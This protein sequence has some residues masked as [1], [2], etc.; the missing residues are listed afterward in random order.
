MNSFSDSSS[1]QFYRN[2]IPLNHIINTKLI[3][4]ALG[5]LLCV[6]GGLFLI[7]MGV[8]LYYHEPEYLDFI[9]SATI[10]FTLGSILMFYGHGASTW[11]TRR[12]GYC[13][14]TLTWILFTLLGMMPFLFSGS[15]PSVSNAFFESMSGFTT[16]GFTVVSNIDDLPRGIQFWRI[17]TQWV[18]ALGIVCFTIAMLPIFGGGNLQLFS[19]E[20]TGVRHDKLHPKI[21][22]NTKLIWTVY[23]LLTGICFGLLY[24][25]GMGGFDSIC[26]SLSIM[27]TGGYSTKQASLAYWDSPFIEYVA[28]IFM[29]I[30]SCNVILLAACMKGRFL[31]LFKD[32][33][34]RW[35]LGSVGLLTA[36]I[37][38][39]LFIS[40]DYSIEKAFRSAFFQVSTIHSSCGLITDDYT[41]W[42]QFTWMLLLF[43]M[44]AGGCTG[45][46]SGAIKNLRIM[47]IFRSIRN[48][49][50]RMIHPNAI[51]PVRVN[52][53]VLPQPMLTTVTVFTIF[54]FICGIIG[55]TLF[56]MMGID[57]F[58][59]LTTA[60]SAMGNIG[61]SFGYYGP[62]FTLDS[63]PELGKWVMSALMLI[64]RLE[65]FNVLILFSA[66]FWDEW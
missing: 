53:H 58:E 15:I 9:Y 52:C 48:E 28:A 32:D 2:R 29:V 64:G 39:T 66:V 10:N 8:S 55:C 3:A 43:A 51:L 57:F 33:E 44:L 35:F 25:G 62:S 40:T 21:S 50:K 22:V 56:M 4:Y 31:K 18:G 38:I 17:L 23:I 63:M 37:T 45:S 59:A 47:I 19:A 42:P 26:H 16:T 11:M 34:T 1:R 14:V 36:I 6:E 12:D 30:S 20:A 60:I 61:V 24:V 5:I 41:K 27:G 49:F 7:C 65:I 54:Y 46:T 13:T